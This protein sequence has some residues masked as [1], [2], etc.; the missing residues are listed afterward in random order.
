MKILFKYATRGRPEWFKET[1]EKYYSKLSGNHKYLFIISM[2][3]DDTTMNNPE[4][5]TYLKSKE[6]L[7]Y[8]YGKNGTKIE[9]IN[10]DME[11]WD[12][13]IL[14]V[15]SDD[16]TP[17]ISGFDAI[18]CKD[19]LRWFPDMDGA[20]HYNDGQTA[21]ALISLSIMTKKMY[22]RFGYIYYPEYD[23][24]WCDNEFM[25]VVY[26]L[27][28]CVYL[29]KIIIRHDWLKKGR[30]AVY[31]RSEAAYNTDKRLFERRKAEGFPTM[32]KGLYSQ[33]NEEGI[34]CEFFKDK[35]GS[36]LDIGA[37]DGQTFSNTRRLAELGWAGVCVEPCPV[38][39]TALL[40]LYAKNPGV[41]LLNAAISPDGRITEFFFSGGDAISSMNLNHKTKWEGQGVK[42]TPYT[43][44]TMT[45][46]EVLKYFGNQFTFLNLDVEGDNFEIFETI[47]LE[48]LD[49]LKMICIEHDSKI[50][51]IEAI[52]SGQG[53]KRLAEN[54]ENLILVK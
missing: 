43:L 31:D 52:A 48:R 17:V 44:K 9:A 46:Q 27:K 30:D 3:H 10:A 4:M 45:V 40:R 21:S 8:Y 1:L 23:S 39:F 11:G 53:F 13:D 2:D 50:N 7:V 42:Y 26:G 34:I 29:D 49:K 36:F 51:E 18:I 19:M 24:L 15:V 35:I 6:D 22:D 20:L 16:M 32:K 41:K 54:A 12:F 14:V 25:E 38:A 5:Q 37:F 28:K 47:P 33:G